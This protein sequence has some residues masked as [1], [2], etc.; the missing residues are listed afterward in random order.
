MRGGVNK[1]K[2]SQQ[3]YLREINA[4]IFRTKEQLRLL[5]SK[6]RGLEISPA[7]NCVYCPNCGE[8]PMSKK[9]VENGRWCDNCAIDLGW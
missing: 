1:L 3:D 8:L 2:Q 9:D 6:R 5:F 4:E 7:S